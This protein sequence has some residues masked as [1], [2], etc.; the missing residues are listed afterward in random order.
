MDMVHSLCY[1][2]MDSKIRLCPPTDSQV[3]VYKMCEI[4]NR[5]EIKYFY[6]MFSMSLENDTLCPLK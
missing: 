3:G 4:N 5:N 6:K 1:Q 2:H